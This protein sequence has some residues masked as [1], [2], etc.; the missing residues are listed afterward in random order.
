MSSLMQVIYRCTG[1]LRSWSS[2]QRLENRDLFTEV[3]TRLEDVTKEFITR[4]EWLH[5]LR[6]A[7]PLV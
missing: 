3:S 1:L 2:L 6:I 4:H 7:P 5:N